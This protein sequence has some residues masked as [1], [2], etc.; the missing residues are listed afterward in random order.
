M[1]HNTSQTTPVT[2]PRNTSRPTNKPSSKPQV[3]HPQPSTT[4]TYY[5]TMTVAVDFARSGQ[6]QGVQPRQP[7]SHIKSIIACQ[8]SNERASTQHTATTKQTTSP[9]TTHSSACWR[10]KTK[11]TACPTFAAANAAAAAAA[12]AVAAAAMQTLQA[13]SQHL[14]LLAALLLLVVHP[15]KQAR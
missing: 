6:L 5:H 9:L 12:A 2:R 13:Q 8:A 1:A 15:K 4:N 3:L 7:H 10:T 11:V 14:L